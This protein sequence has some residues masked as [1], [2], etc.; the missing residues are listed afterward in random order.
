LSGIS[1]ARPATNANFSP[2]AWL[3]VKPDTG[4]K[5]IASSSSAPAVSQPSCARL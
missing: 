4:E 1:I 2:A 3:A 5:K